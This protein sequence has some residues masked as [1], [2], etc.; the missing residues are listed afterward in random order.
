MKLSKED[1]K[2][3]IAEVVKDDDLSISLLEDIEDSWQEQ[4][5]TTEKDE[6]IKDLTS[7]LEDLTQKYKERFLTKDTTTQEIPIEDPNKNIFNMVE[8]NKKEPLR[9]ED[10]IDFEKGEIK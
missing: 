5:A 8:E 4:P 9:F 2:S 6:Q 3:K 1:L 7:K 10:L